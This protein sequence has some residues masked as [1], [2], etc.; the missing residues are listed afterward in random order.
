M[1]ARTGAMR[2][3]SEFRFNDEKDTG[4][5]YTGLDWSTL[6]DGKGGKVVGLGDREAAHSL[7]FDDLLLAGDWAGDWGWLGGGGGGGGVRNQ[8]ASPL[9]R[10]TGGGNPGPGGLR[11]RQAIIGLTANA[12]FP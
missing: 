1:L 12:Q 6:G 8:R 11:R 4:D 10:G 3:G 7:H 2:P 5:T 9:L